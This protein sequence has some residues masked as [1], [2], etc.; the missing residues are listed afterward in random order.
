MKKGCLVLA[1]A[2]LTGCGEEAPKGPVQFSVDTKDELVLKVLPATRLACPGLSRYSHDFQDVRVEQQYRTAIVFH[3]PDHSSIPDTYKAGGHNCFIEIEGDGSA[4]LIEK[5]ACKSVC[6]DQLDVPAGQ[7]KLTLASDEEV[8][9]RECLT[10][11]DYD[12]TTQ[13]TFEK[14]KPEHCQKSGT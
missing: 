5:L 6:L 4:I 13:K 9:L 3:V 12:P 14:P 11:Y 10:S 2:L 1:V 8:K 7:L